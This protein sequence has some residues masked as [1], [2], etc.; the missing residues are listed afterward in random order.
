MESEVISP[1]RIRNRLSEG[2]ADEI[3]FR[4]GVHGAATWALATLL[5]ALIAFGGAQALT[6]LAAPSSSSAG[7]STS[8]GSEN[9][10]A[11]D[12]DRLFRGARSDVNI[13]YSRAEAGRI[14]WCGWRRRQTSRRHA[15]IA[16]LGA[17]ATVI[18]DL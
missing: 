13:E 17:T 6:R 16:A 3:E 11:Y 15:T 12:I 2:T 10:I 18:F 7:P 4:D 8:V 14:Q 9:I 5:T 1:G